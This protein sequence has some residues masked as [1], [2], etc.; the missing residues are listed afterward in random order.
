[1]TTRPIPRPSPR[2]RPGSSPRLYWI[3]ACAGMTGTVDLRRND[4]GG[5]ACHARTL[6]LEAAR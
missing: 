4:R 2:R 3:P 1:M 5:M 6:P